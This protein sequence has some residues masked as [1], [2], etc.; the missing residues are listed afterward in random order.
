[1]NNDLVSVIA[2]VYNVV[3]LIKQKYVVILKLF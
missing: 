1:M 2:P 3:S